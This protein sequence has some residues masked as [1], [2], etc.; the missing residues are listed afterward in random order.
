MTTEEVFA[1]YF[2][3]QI[4]YTFLG[5][6]VLIL[7]NTAVG[8]LRAIVDGEFEADHVTDYMRKHILPDGGTLALFG[9]AATVAPEAKALFFAATATAVVKYGDKLRD[10]L[11][12]QSLIE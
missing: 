8:I 1:P 10:K 4:V 5:V 2:D 3:P 9:L 11:Q 12:K 7:L 6:L